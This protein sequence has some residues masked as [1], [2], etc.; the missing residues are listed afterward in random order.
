MET[1]F[2]GAVQISKDLKFLILGIFKRSFLM[3]KCRKDISRRKDKGIVP[4]GQ[5]GIHV[6]K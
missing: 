1:C 4:L 2:W 6:G 3:C 5:F